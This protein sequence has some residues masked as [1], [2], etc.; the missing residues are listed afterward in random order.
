[1]TTPETTMVDQVDQ[2]AALI[3]SPRRCRVHAEPKPDCRRCAPADPVETGDYLA[4]MW[5]LVRALEARTIDDPSVLPQVV[6]LAARLTEVANVAVATNAARYALDPRRGAS[7]GECAR[8]LGISK[9]SVSDRRKL[10]ERII[11][12]RLAAAVGM[13][14][15]EAARERA[16]IT[17]AAESAAEP[18]A[19]YRA[20]HAA[21]VPAGG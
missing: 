12:E 10:G 17:A 6:A 14:H 15:S 2:F 11:A 19:G 3:R 20:R 21:V 7:A 16:A 1:M 18:L 13:H 5:R 4:M 9:Q 8:A